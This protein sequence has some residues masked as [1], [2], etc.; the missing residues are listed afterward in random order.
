M[1]DEHNSRVLVVDDEPMITDL[2]STMLTTVGYKCSTTNSG[3]QALALLKNLQ[4]DVVVT[5]IR[6][7]EMSGIELLEAIRSSFPDIA[8]IM[9]TAE[10]DRKIAIHTLE[11]GAY[12]YVIKPFNR[13]E[14][15]I[16]VANALER[17][18]LTMLSQ[19]YERSLEQTV[20]QRTREVREREED[21]IFRL[22]SATRYRDDETGAHVKR[23]GL[24]AAEMANA[25][26]WDKQAVN[27]IRLAG[28]MHD[29]GKIGVPDGV[30]L[31]PGKLEPEEFETIKKHSEI[32]AA[33]LRGSNVALLQMAEQIAWCHH[34][35]WDGSGYPR[36]LSGDD[37][38]ESGRIVAVVDV[39]DALVNDRIY[40]PAMP[41]EKA[42]SIMSQTNGSHFD[43]KLFECFMD[44][45]P[46][47]RNILESVRDDLY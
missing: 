26:G 46:T 31:K 41:E 17:R 42:L 44:L 23:I 7:P 19:D 40:R 9:A 21:I 5:D 3:G 20:E 25:L 6:M 34:E 37:I 4:F 14:I 2:I 47:M 16:N 28:P 11:L 8:V 35:K 22:I 45:R 12:G 32:G 29:L 27:D 33:I 1:V 13:N 36:G 38:P 39:Y 24:Y 18:R 43:R 30:L 15:L 10:D